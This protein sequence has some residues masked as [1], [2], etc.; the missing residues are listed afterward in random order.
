MQDTPWRRSEPF[1]YL[2]YQMLSFN[3]M[4]NVREKQVRECLES[5]LRILCVNF[6]LKNIMEHRKIFPWCSAWY[7][8]LSLIETFWC[9]CVEAHYLLYDKVM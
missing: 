5:E 8:Y 1:T 9:V 2:G 7:E 6:F 4:K 3:G